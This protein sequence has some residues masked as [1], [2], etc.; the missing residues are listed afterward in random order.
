MALYRMI[1]VPL[2]LLGALLLSPFNRKI[3]QT[4]GL[5]LHTV[6]WPDW[7]GLAPTLWVHCASGEF[8]Y[9]KPVI[10]EWRKL[11]PQGRVF[12]TYY[13]PSFKR[14][15]EQAPEVDGS[16][17]LPLDLPGPMR[18]FL[19]RLKPEVLAVSRTD[20][21]PEMCVQARLQKVPIVLFS[22][23]HSKSGFRSGFAFLKRWQLSLVDRILTV[24][25]QDAENLRALKVQPDITA[26]GDSRYDQ[27]QHRLIH[28]RETKLY[29]KPS[30]SQRVLVAGSTWPADEAVLTKA[31]ADHLSQGRLRLII[32]PHECDESHLKDIERAFGTQHVS[33]QRYSLA[34]SWT[35][36]VLI[37]D[38]VGV[39]AELYQWGQLAFVGGSF[40][41]SVHSVMEPL[42]AGCLTFVGPFHSNNREALEFKSLWLPPDRHMVEVVNDS[43]DLNL[44]IRS[45]LGDAEAA[46]W[47]DKIRQAVRDRSGASRAIAEI[48]ISLS[49]QTPH[50]PSDQTDTPSSPLPV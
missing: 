37:V 43:R 14:F 23:T 13:S 28:P 1:I 12:V 36:P 44:Q 48:L 21:W 19:R 33:T 35:S 3:R 25:P 42:A 27:V 2:L 11:R 16:A 9:A 18:E 15:V 4:L 7:T 47:P 46:L 39:L 30:S 17:P 40:R 22:A 45:V 10:R 49:G 29:L 5:R 24:S 26:L 34:E 8:E 20:L 6:N 31:L 32:A 41:G 38:Q 50:R